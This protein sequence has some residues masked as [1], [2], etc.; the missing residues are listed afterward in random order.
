[1]GYQK[2]LSRNA[3]TM[4]SRH[5]KGPSD[6]RRLKRTTKIS[7]G[8]MAEDRA[9]WLD[10]WSALEEYLRSSPEAL[11]RLEVQAAAEPKLRS[12][13]EEYGSQ[14]KPMVRTDLTQP[15]RAELTVPEWGESDLFADI[16]GNQKPCVLIAL[17]QITDTR[18]LGAIARSAAFFGI[19]WLIM[20]KDR[21]ASI[22]GGTIS[23]AQGAFAFVRP[24]FV[25]N[26][27]RTLIE[28]KELGFWVLGTDM[29]GE[30]VN[31]VTGQYE[32]VVL[33][34]GSE[35]R[36]MRSLTRRNCDRM[37][38]IPRAA[39]G[40]ESLNVA[41]AAGIFLHELRSTQIPQ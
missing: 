22:T 11:V 35:D 25:T 21:Q 3:T 39:R 31:A 12:L 1:L 29:E 19:P 32:R 18:N 13:L 7:T 4:N 2:I 17:D 15:F 5:S 38:A 28:L 6:Q 37:I 27:S 30:P 24:V 10:S 26:L 9:L 33:V 16:S 23:A 40:V 8:T 36:G 20:P 41:V 34:L 14:L